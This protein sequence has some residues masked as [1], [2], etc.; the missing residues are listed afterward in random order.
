LSI[1]VTFPKQVGDT[2]CDSH[3][4]AHTDSITDPLTITLALA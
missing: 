4:I 2:N 1:A 3:S